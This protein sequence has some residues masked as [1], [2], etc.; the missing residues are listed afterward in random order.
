MSGRILQVPRHLRRGGKA[1]D[2]D[3]SVA[4]GLQLIQL[5]C[6]RFNLPGLGGSSVL[7]MGCGCK[8]VQALLEYDLAVGR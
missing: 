7:D 1:R 5:M 3:E 8:L 6:R 4:S 2:E